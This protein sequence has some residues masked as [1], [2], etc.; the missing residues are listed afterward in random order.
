MSIFNWTHCNLNRI[1]VL[2]VRKR[3]EGILSGQLTVSAPEAQ[4]PMG[5]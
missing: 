3:G 4:G 1:G 2:L 5:A